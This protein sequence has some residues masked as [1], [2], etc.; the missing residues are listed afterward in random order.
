MAKI[1]LTTHQKGGVGKSTLS[2]NL[3]VNLKEN[4][5]VC[6]IDLDAQGSLYQVR[7]LSEVPIFPEEKLKKSR[8][9]ILILFLLIHLHICLTNLLNCAILQML[10]LFLQK[11]EF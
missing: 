11:Q 9:Q 6:I 4:A 3:A 2:F 5:K 10:L 7:D 1:I 8:V